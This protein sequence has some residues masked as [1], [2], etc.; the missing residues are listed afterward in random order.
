MQIDLNTSSPLMQYKILSNAL[1]PRPIAWISTTSPQGVINLAPFSF[2]G[3]ISSDPIILSV[4]LTPKSDGTP[5]DTLKNILETKKATICMCDEKNLK[6]LHQTSAELEYEK[7]E[8]IAFQIEL[9]LIEAN[10]PPIAQGSL[11]AFMC[12]LYDVLEISQ[13]SKTILLEAKKC[14]ID[15]TIYRPDLNFTLKNI[16]RNGKYYQPASTL[17]DP[18]SL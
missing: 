7:S 13:S 14:F 10:Y 8:A 9:A 15:D 4:C 18:K 5:K 12:E 16:G 2:F 11:L 17:L 1:T 3:P 6:A